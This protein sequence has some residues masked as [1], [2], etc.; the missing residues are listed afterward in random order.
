VAPPRHELPRTAWRLPRSM[1]S[2][3]QAP[4]RL[5]QPLEDTPFYARATVQATLLGETVTA[6]HE[7]LSLPRV[8]SWPVQ[9]MLPWRMPRRG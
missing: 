2:A 5:L 7:T 8:V 1:R 3:A 9:G 4:A 6:M